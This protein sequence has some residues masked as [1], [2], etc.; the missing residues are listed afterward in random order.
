MT[1]LAVVHRLMVGLNL[2]YFPILHWALG[3]LES[4]SLLNPLC[5]PPLS[6]PQGPLSTAGEQDRCSTSYTKTIHIVSN[7]FAPNKELPS[8]VGEAAQCYGTAARMPLQIQLCHQLLTIFKGLP[9]QIQP[10][11]FKKDS[12]HA[13]NP[14]FEKVQEFKQIPQNKKGHWFLKKCKPLPGAS[15]CWPPHPSCS[16]QPNAFRCPTHSTFPQ[17]SSFYGDRSVSAELEK[18]GCVKRQAQNE[19]LAGIGFS[20]CSLKKEVIL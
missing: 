9:I 15:L 2:G 11:Y 16:Q 12:A 5:F 20:V 6:C 3:W 8:P 13:E 1:D 14:A 10:S 19:C 18:Q 7:A 4:F 17:P